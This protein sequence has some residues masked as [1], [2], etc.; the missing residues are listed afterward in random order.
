MEY[1]M[2][3]D[4]IKTIS[5]FLILISLPLFTKCSSKNDSITDPYSN[6][7]LAVINLTDFQQIIRGFGGV[8]MPGWIAD[9]TPGQINKAFGTGD[10]QIGLSILRIRVPYD[11]S[12]FNLEVPTAQLAKSLGAIII[13][14][15]WS[16]PPSMKTN[17]NIVEGYLN[18][19]SYSA[20]A[21]YLKSFVDYMANNGASLYAVSIQNEPDVTVDYES[22]YWNASQMIKFIKNNS[23]SIGVKIIAPESY[24]FNHTYADSIL[25]DD[26]AASK[27][28]IIGGHIYDTKISSYSAAAAKGKEL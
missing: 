1:D 24:N 7:N 22:C 21:S 8:N 17:N 15:P 16:P 3:I 11:V 26:E 9:M 4:K 23:P 25:N 19:S 5:I 6:G 28:S 27:I 18:S 13:A 2:R 12:V 10:G 20:Y 14:T